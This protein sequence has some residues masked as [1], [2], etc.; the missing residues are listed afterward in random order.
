MIPYNYPTIAFP[1]RAIFISDQVS[2]LREDGHFV[3]VISALPKT[4]SDVLRTSRDENSNKKFENGIIAYPAIRGFHSFNRTIQFY[5]LRHKLIGKLEKDKANNQLPDVVHVHNSTSAKIAIWIKKEFGIPFVITEHS[6]SMWNYD[7]KSDPLK[8]NDAI[9]LSKANMAVS[10]DF[11]A[12]LSKMFE[13]QFHY[14]PNAVDTAFFSRAGKVSSCSKDGVL[15]LISVGNLT[16]NKNHQLA[17]RAVKLL[18]EKGVSVQYTIIGAGAEL[19]FLKKL[20]AKLNLTTK[21]V[22]KGQLDRGAVKE[23]LIES[24]RFLFPSLRETFG[25]VLIEAMACG[26]PV[27][28]LNNGG[29]DSIITNPNVGIIS[30]NEA[31]FCKDI[32]YFILKDYDSDVI[33][34]FTHKLFSYS[35]VVDRLISLYR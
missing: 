14:V 16:K 8:L 6:S 30:V 15:K 27:I 7:A 24:D 26:L 9:S 10:K 3:E 13:C 31:Q 34:N 1:N 33:V 25:V 23:C 20:A 11:A 32:E 22:F 2:A 12:H 19:S 28:A 4:M 17:I 35:S 5:I 18:V 21:V 29:S